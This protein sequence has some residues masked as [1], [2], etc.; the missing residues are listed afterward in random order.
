MPAMFGAGPV[1]FSMRRH[2]GGLSGFTFLDA[3][4]SGDLVDRSV[5]GQLVDLAVVNSQVSS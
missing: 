5:L 1:R 2:V 3:Q 4:V